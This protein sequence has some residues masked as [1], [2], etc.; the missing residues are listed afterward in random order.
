MVE[1]YHQG[2]RDTRETKKELFAF[3]SKK[4]RFIW[5]SHIFPAPGIIRPNKYRIPDFFLSFI[6]LYKKY[7]MVEKIDL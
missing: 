2:F 4:F 3:H 6:L 1:F 5:Y 7:K